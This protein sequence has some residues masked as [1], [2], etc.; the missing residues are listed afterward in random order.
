MHN[1]TSTRRG[2]TSRPGWRRTERVPSGS[3]G[4]T[5]EPE[6]SLLLRRGLPA[7]LRF[8]RHLPSL[9]LARGWVPPPF[10]GTWGTL[11]IGRPILVALR[12]PVVRLIRHAASV[13]ASDRSDTSPSSVPISAGLRLK[14][15]NFA[16]Q[17]KL[18][19]Q[20]MSPASSGFAR[21]PQEISASHNQPR[22]SQAASSRMIRPKARTQSLHPE[23]GKA[24][25]H[26]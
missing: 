15:S 17:S 5:R 3:R 24:R 7:S 26:R 20:D 4:G 9:F 13:E 11:H 18:N 14:T 2:Q 1:L 22:R 12:W 25:V 21:R 23:N 19:A 16:I 6:A 10:S 8:L